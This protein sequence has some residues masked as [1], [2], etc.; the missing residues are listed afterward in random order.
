[1]TD[2]EDVLHTPGLGVEYQPRC[3]DMMI[4]LVVHLF[5]LPVTASPFLHEI[6]VWDV[7]DRQCTQNQFVP[8]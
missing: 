2:S 8:A 3:S 7:F 6:P 4:E 1:M 5:D